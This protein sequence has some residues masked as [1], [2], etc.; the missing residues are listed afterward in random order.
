[1]KRYCLILLLPF[2]YL[3]ALAADFTQAE[4]SYREGHFAAALGQYEQLLQNYPNDPH[5]YY[6]IGNCYFK[7]G[8]KG[9]AIANYYRAFRL[10][11]RDT[12]I[13]H[14][15]G[16][17]LAQAGERLVP[18]GVPEILHVAFFWLTAA[19]L[20]ASLSI[21]W[22]LFC[23]ATA[24]WLLKH[25]YG[26]VV[27]SLAIALALVATWYILRQQGDATHLAVV[28]PPVAELRSGPGTNFPA[29]ANISQGHLLLLQD[30]RD[31]WQE[32]VVKSQGIKGWMN[33]A[34]LEN[35]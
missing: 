28:A 4:Q 19:E 10:A 23:L 5:L 21:I 8:S 2:L 15:L 32:V 11:P 35:I 9:L 18:S 27:F 13:R 17:A 24:V 6:N 12:D 3:S 30:S 31:N 1:M 7:M 29:S 25:R 14:N 22:W 34:D 26:K 20:K 33:A 16:L